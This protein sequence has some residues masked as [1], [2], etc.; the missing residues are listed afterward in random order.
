MKDLLGSV[1]AQILE[2]LKDVMVNVI[3][4]TGAATVILEGLSRRR[5]FALRARHERELEILRSQIEREREVLA[6]VR[7]I[8]AN[9]AT[10]AHAKVLES[11]S[12]MWVDILAIRDFASKFYMIYELLTREEITDP[13]NMPFLRARVEH[14]DDKEWAEAIDRFQAAERHRPFVGEAL[15]RLFYVYRAVSLRLA[16]KVREG[17]KRKRVPYWDEGLDGKPDALIEQVL[18]IA[19][20]RDEVL[21]LVKPA[22]PI[23]GPLRICGALESKIIEEMSQWIFGQ[24]QA[25]LSLREQERMQEA[26]RVLDKGI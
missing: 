14:V 3:L 18:G 6:S 2:S 26:I 1:G 7:G 5:E 15:Y 10:G 21:E 11:L 20:S 17:L 24:R 19:L 13:S 8:I 23:G 9:S 22:G 4:S 25:A 12:A 16:W